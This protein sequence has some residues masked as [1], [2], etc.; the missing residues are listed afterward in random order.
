MLKDALR[1]KSD[2]FNSDN[3][4]EDKVYLLNH[5]LSVNTEASSTRCANV[6][7]HH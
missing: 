6:D 2:I 7:E 5:W 4:E 1:E 3:P